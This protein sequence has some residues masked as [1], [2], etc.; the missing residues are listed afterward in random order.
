MTSAATRAIAEQMDANAAAKRGI[1]LIA[2]GARVEL[3]LASEPILI[4]AT[5]CD[6]YCTLRIEGEQNRLATQGPCV[7]VVAQPRA[8]S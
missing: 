7:H 6:K 8:L 3:D 5:L 2:G 1:V 4:D